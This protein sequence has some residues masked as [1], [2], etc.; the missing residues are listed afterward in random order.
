M[1]HKHEWVYAEA[2]HLVCKHCLI[3]DIE[4]IEEEPKE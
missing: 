2:S 3:K 1:E 4:R